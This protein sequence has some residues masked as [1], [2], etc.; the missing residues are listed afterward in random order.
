MP[1]RTMDHND[2]ARL[3]SVYLRPWTLH[4]EL[5]S[6]VVRHLADLDVIMP[7]EALAQSRRRLSYKSTL[8]QQAQRG[9]HA[10]WR[11]YIRG[12]VVSEHARRLIVNFLGACATTTT[13]DKDSDDEAVPRPEPPCVPGMQPITTA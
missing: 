12:R 1:S 8:T 10:A 2:R 3:L 5:S 6:F 11:Q 9:F 13:Q 4:R 7:A